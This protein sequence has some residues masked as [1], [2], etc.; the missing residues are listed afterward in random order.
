MDPL[1]L[2]TR[3]PRRSRRRGRN[4]SKM[5]NISRDLAKAC[6][7]LES[8]ITQ[9][10]EGQTLEQTLE[11]PAFTATQLH[12]LKLTNQYEDLRVKRLEETMAHKLTTLM[13]K[14]EQ[15][16]GSKLCDVT[17]CPGRALLVLPSCTHV[18]CYNCFYQFRGAVGDS[19][20]SQR[21]CCVM[22]RTSIDPD[23]F[24]KLPSDCC[25]IEI[26]LH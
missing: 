17:F 2:P 21:T 22:C 11:S 12:M 19:A 20:R 8:T 14:R 3:K 1:A 23:D 10:P 15:D 5:Y 16:G 18:Y 25:Q 9:R 24:S 4:K 7:Q 13:K 6:A 26:A